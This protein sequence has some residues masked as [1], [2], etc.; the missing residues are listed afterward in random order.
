MAKISS[1][2]IYKYLKILDS[3]ILGYLV[4]WY[5]H[6][7]INQ[8]HNPEVSSIHWLW[9]LPIKEWIPV[10]CKT[11]PTPACFWAWVS[12]NWSIQVYVAGWQLGLMIFVIEIMNLMNLLVCK[13][14]YMYVCTSSTMYIQIYLVYLCIV[15]IACTW[16]CVVD[17]LCSF[18]LKFCLFQR[19]FPKYI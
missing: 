12:L 15:Y 18:N 16:L 4:Q 8:F 11:F 13:C 19:F 7:W 3:S 14:T 9:Y 1:Y 6:P 5:N 17:F 2:N 10:M